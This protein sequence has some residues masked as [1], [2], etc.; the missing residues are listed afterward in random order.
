MSNLSDGV[1]RLVN[2]AT[3]CYMDVAGNGFASGTNVIIWSAVENGDA[4]VFEV[5][6]RSNGSRRIQN[7]MSGKN[8][9]VQG[10]TAAAGTNVRI[11]QEKSL[12][13]AGQALAIT[14]TGNT[15]TP[16]GSS[17]ALETYY[18]SMA[19][20]TSYTFDIT[21]SAAGASV[22][23]GNKNS[24]QASRSNEWVFVPVPQFESGGLYEIRSYLD[25]ARLTLDIY[26]SNPANGTNLQIYG[27]NH[28]NNQKFFITEESSGQYSIRCL[29]SGKYIDVSQGI[30]AN[31]T[32]VQAWQDNDLTPQRWNMMPYGT[33][34]IDGKTCLV[35]RFGSFCTPDAQ[36]YFMDVSAAQTS[37]ETNVQIWQYIATSQAQLFVLY[38]T[39]AE[40]P[41]MPVPYDFGVQSSINSMPS[42]YSE[43]PQFHIGWKCAKSWAGDGTNHYE[44]RYRGRHMVP[45]TSAWGAWT[46]WSQ[47]ITAAAET[48]G[49][50]AWTPDT[51]EDDYE[52]EDAKNAEWEF[53]LRAAGADDTKVIHGKFIDNTINVY[54]EPDIAVISAGWSPDGLVLGAVCDYT[55]GTAVINVE[56]IR[57]MRGLVA[58]PIFKGDIALELHGGEGSVVIPNDL[59]LSYPVNGA[60]LTIKFKPG[61]DQHEKFNNSPQTSTAFLSYDAGSQ[62]V[63][64]TFARD[65]RRL[66]ATVPNLG[67][68]HM[69]VRYDNTLYECEEL[70]PGGALPNTQFEVLYPMGR[71][72]D[73]FTEAHN[74][75]RTAWGTDM[76]TVQ[77]VEFQAHAFTFNRKTVYIDQFRKGSEQYSRS[78]DAT[79][80]ADVLDS[81]EHES[82]SFGATVKSSYSIT[83]VLSAD[84]TVEEVAEMVGEHVIY[85]TP[86]GGLVYAAITGYTATVRDGY[87]EVSI[88]LIEETR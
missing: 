76:T 77:A 60:S 17:T 62:S 39:E 47:W 50:R 44:Y 20:A 5:S 63:R 86:D 43:S 33:K 73:V 27:V 82:V 83:G 7:R 84:N 52:W 26:K 69:W 46:A 18:I 55:D 30:A 87:T 81:R 66:I 35:V 37:Y 15:Y 22:V 54:K 6:T 8:A 32:N 53:Q 74:A 14:S 64:P 45:S 80:S 75:T 85:R 38:P 31:G 13:Y 56:Q 57:A 1:Y 11:W 23:L 2:V 3:G 41:T 42:K 36:T 51:Y 4:Q 58:T 65:G 10:S 48:N 25:P 9:D 40:D 71:D 16:S 67:E 79:Y 34:V 24:P 61:Y 21:S 29:H 68:Q 78:G 70:N 49:V 59:L 19:S 12:T 88:N 72:F 28:T